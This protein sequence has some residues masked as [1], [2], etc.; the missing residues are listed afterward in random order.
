MVMIGNA[1]L[2]WRLSFAT[3]HEVCATAHITPETKAGRITSLFTSGLL[4]MLCV[5]VV[6]VGVGW[7][8]VGWGGCYGVRVERWS[9]QKS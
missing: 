1:T 9:K 8:G 7:G 2:S 5:C 4:R 6:F 3:N